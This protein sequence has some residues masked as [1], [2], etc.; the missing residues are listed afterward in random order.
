MAACARISFHIYILQFL[1]KNDDDEDD[2]NIKCNFV[3]V[4]TELLHI[5][6][7]INMVYFRHIIVNIMRQGDNK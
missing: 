7:P 5:V 3:I 2:K 1:N 6:Y 4:T